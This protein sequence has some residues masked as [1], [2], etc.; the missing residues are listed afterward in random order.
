[1]RKDTLTLFD[2]YVPSSAGGYATSF[3]SAL[4]QNDALGQ[5]NALELYV[6]VDNVPLTAATGNLLVFVEHSCDGRR[7]ICRGDGTQT[8]D[9]TVFTSAIADMVVFVD[10]GSQVCAG[11][12]SDACRGQSL[13][14]YLGTA[15]TG[16]L[17]TYVRLRM[18][19]DTTGVE[20]HVRVDA[21]RRDR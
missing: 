1:M 12:F 11:S 18:F 9:S 21:A 15:I 4:E 2:E 10:A 3:F 16:P 5:F 17:L 19:F 14:P 8:G 20:G 6:K 7:W 13:V